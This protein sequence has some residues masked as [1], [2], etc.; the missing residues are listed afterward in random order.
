MV[1]DDVKGHQQFC[2]ELMDRPGEPKDAES[3]TQMARVPQAPASVVDPER[4]VQWS[5]QAA[6]KHSEARFSH[7]LGLAQYRAGHFDAAIKSIEKSNSLEWS[8]ASVK[9]Q[10]W[11]I[12]AMAHHRLGHTDEAR[13]CSDTAQKLIDEA[14]PKKPVE[15]VDM[16]AADWISIRVLSRE[17][18]SLLKEAAQNPE[19][20]LLT[21]ES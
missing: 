20:M 1:L 8:P 12:L 5:T 7:V 14:K 2:Q 4:F 10:N 11:L 17:A 6:E 9:A 13:K 19:P 16:P 18:E 21:T 3:A 15:P